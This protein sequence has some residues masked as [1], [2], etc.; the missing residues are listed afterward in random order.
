MEMTSSHAHSRSWPSGLCNTPRQIKFKRNYLVPLVLWN[1]VIS[2]CS[3]GFICKMGYEA[4]KT[5]EEIHPQLDA[6][7]N[8]LPQIKGVISE[9][10]EIKEAV[11]KVEELPDFGELNELLGDVRDALQAQPQIKK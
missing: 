10:D 2:A 1:I 8:V 6:L 5:M 11:A 7:E 3:L 9:I 4:N